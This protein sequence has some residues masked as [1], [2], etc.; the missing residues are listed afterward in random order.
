MNIFI[1]LIIFLLTSPTGAEEELPS[2]AAIFS[3]S[4]KPI[5]KSNE[6]FSFGKCRKIVHKGIENV[7]K[8]S[9]N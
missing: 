3:S 4:Q 7:V 2:D 9:S 5:C 1:I 8:S 6:R